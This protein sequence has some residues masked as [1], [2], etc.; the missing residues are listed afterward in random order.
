MKLV[1]VESPSK[2]KTVAKYLGNDYIVDAS[3]GHIRELPE[4]NLNVDVNNNFEPHY[5]II[6]T[7][8][9]AVKRL[10]EKVKKSESVLLATDPDREGEAISWH[11][12]TVLGLP[13]NAKNRITFN[14][15]SKKAVE[16]SIAN[17][18]YINQNLVNAQQARR[19]LD[20]LVGYKLSPVLCKK[21]QPKLS[22]GRVQSAALKLIVDREREIK[23]FVPEEYWNISALL[24]NGNNKPT[25]KALLATCKGK[26]I[27]ITCEQDAKNVLTVIDSKPF[28]VASLKKSIN[29]SSPYPPFTTSTMQQD[30]VNKLRMSSNKCMQVAQQLYEGVDIKGEHMALVTYIRT[31]SVRISTDAHNDARAYIQ[32]NF[33]ADYV[34]STPNYYATKKSAQDAHEAIRPINVALTP[35]SIK[36]SISADQYKLYKLIYDRFLASCASKAKYDSVAVVIDCDNYGFKANGKT[37]LF[38]GYTRFYSNAVKGDEDTEEGK[39]P[40]MNEGDI[41]TLH[42]IDSEQKFTKAPS[43]YTEAS[44]IKTMEEN[45]IGRPSTFATIISTIL[46]R[47]YVQKDSKSFLPTELGSIVTEYM[48]KYFADIVNVEFTSGLE[49]KLDLIEE[50][51]KVQWQ[52][53]VGDFYYPMMKNIDTALRDKAYTTADDPINP[54]C[55]K[56]G[57]PMVVMVGKFGRYLKCTNVD[58]KDTQLIEHQEQPRVTDIVCDKCGAFMVEKTGRFG[59]FYACPNY[60][61]CKNTMPIS[62]KQPKSVAV[63]AKCGGQIMEKTTKRGKIFYGCSNYPKCDYASW[64][65]PIDKACPICGTNLSIKNGDKCDQYKCTNKDCDYTEDIINK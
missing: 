39:L 40:I 36:A 35:D 46:N 14:E 15:I 20:R 30:A 12:Q 24:Q 60:P 1:I 21:I 31:D 59:K 3:G 6:A 22:A 47:K 17:P 57:S 11:L 19:V 52:N 5:E 43:R 62:K 2:A 18:D 44:L 4:K 63:C 56:C 27:K 29:Y 51:N 58:C 26:K 7:K 45:G 13:V 65:L 28:T 8:K 16:K 49:D 50:D 55:S 9:D 25:F 41:L 34:P 23:S 38:D 54:V 32:V 42:S 61:E 37:V 53:V 48:E 33:G 64:D 10:K